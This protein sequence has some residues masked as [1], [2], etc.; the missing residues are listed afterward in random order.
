M[1]KKASS[2]IKKETVIAII[3]GL[4]GIFLVGTGVLAYQKSV[5]RHEETLKQ[6]AEHAIAMCQR[7]IK[8]TESYGIKLK[9]EEALLKEAETAL[10]NRDYR[11]AEDKADQARL[12]AL[13]LYQK[14]LAKKR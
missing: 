8:Q 2:R 7:Q 1:K 9:G 6:N 13:A 14:Q 4:I 10:S 5:K 3:L 12:E 11:E